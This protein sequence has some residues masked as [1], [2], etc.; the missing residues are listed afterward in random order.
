MSLAPAR[1]ELAA[2]LLA[3]RDSLQ[4]NPAAARVVFRARTRLEQGVQCSASVRRLPALAVDEPAELGGGDTAMGPVDLLLVALGTCQEIVYSIHAA[5]MGIPLDGVSVDVKGQLDLRGLFAMDEAVPA[6]CRRISFETRIESAADPLLV[7]RLVRVAESSCP[8]LDT[9][10]SPLEVSGT[11]LLN[12][13][14][15]D[16]AQPEAA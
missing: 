4:R 7:A 9:L 15:L 13:R 6:G 12:G 8:V 14:R 10:L 2:K 16:A 1:A 11:V 3:K 5:L